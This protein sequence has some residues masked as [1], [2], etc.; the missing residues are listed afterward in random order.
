MNTCKLC[1]NPSLHEVCTIC[2]LSLRNL[3]S[4]TL[5]KLRNSVRNRKKEIKF[6]E[7]LA[8]DEVPEEIK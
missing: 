7:S 8:S 4:K 6:K 5:N 2:E 1:G 3:N